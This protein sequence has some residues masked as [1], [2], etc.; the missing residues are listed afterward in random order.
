MGG[1]F[2]DASRVRTD[3]QA[4][5]IY[6]RPEV[7]PNG[8]SLSAQVTDV[9]TEIAPLVRAGTTT[10]VP[11]AELMQV[12]GQSWR[13]VGRLTGTGGRSKIRNEARDEAAAGQ[14]E[15]SHSAHVRHV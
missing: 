2:F 5:A 11:A 4:V 13:R 14:Q 7:T 1:S 3:A 10:S 9:S 8:R 12:G 6:I 15:R